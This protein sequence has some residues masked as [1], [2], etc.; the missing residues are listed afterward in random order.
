MSPSID[1]PAHSL[2]RVVFERVLR[3]ECLVP[4]GRRVQTQGGYNACLAVA[5]KS[6]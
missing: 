4:E 3:T 2:L 6:G 5:A 1:A